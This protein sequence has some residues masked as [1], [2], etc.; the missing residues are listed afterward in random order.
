[1]SPISNPEDHAKAL[2]RLEEL[3]IADPPP[4]SSEDRE[5]GELALKIESHERERIQIP[6]PT[7]EEKRLFWIEQ[8]Q[9]KKHSFEPT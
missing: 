9:R 1:V 8:A 5:L 4:G 2:E 7:A 6:K 3:M